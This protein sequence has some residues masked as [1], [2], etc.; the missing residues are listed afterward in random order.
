MKLDT[1]FIATGNKHKLVEIRDALAPFSVV[2]KAL[3][4]NGVMPEETGAS[5]AANAK[6]KAQYGFSLT[7]LPTLADD[8]GLEVAALGGAPGVFSAR[9][10]GADAADGANNA[11]LL[12]AL[13]GVANRR[14][15]FRCAMALVTGPTIIE[16][17]GLCAGVIL[18]SPKG[19]GGFGYDPLFFL[20]QFNKT[21]AELPLWQKNQVSHRSQALANLL[22]ALKNRG[23]V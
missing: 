21:M 20:P 19:N 18:E 14:A 4:G 13:A 1:L 16:A 2:V 17:E 22:A 3:P 12:A 15:V 7:G 5:F 8:S 6:S 11:K 9:Y 10:A 23:L